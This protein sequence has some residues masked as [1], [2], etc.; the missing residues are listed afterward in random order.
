VAHFNSPYVTA[1]PWSSGFGT[2]YANPSTLPANICFDVAFSP[3]DADI[4]L[5]V[6]TSPFVEAYAW[7]SGFGAKYSSPSTL[8]ANQGNSVTFSHA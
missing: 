8:P 5:A 6:A 3:D 2:K 4:A 7:S 1:Y